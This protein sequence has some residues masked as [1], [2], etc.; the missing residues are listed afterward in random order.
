MCAS[1]SAKAGTQREIPRLRNTRP[2]DSRLRGN[3][4]MWVRLDSNG[5]RFRS[6]R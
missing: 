3:E 4:R 2:L 1:I 6:G 5:M